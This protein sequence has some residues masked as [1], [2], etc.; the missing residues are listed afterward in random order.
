M[1]EPDMNRN[2]STNSPSLDRAVDLMRDSVPMRAEWR[3]AVLR[4]VS[5]APQPEP[6]LSPSFMP[7]VRG[8]TPAFLRSFVVHPFAA[9]AACVAAML[10]GA[11]GTLAFVRADA[12]ATP[13][14]AAVNSTATTV[15]LS[16]AA[17]TS[18]SDKR[19]IIRFALVA[20]GA[21]QVSIVGDF[22]NWDPRATPLKTARDGSTWLIDMPLSAGRHVYAFVVDGDL[23][24]D[25]SAPRV[26]DHDFGVQNSVVLVGSL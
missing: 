2:S 25:P 20:P 21:G 24:A 18:S 19:K 10:I 16:N 15:P 7:D 4:E 11:A 1:L 5:A 6:K 26:V 9:V 13:S 23:V 22:N 17:N 14:V 12:A 3:D 8:R